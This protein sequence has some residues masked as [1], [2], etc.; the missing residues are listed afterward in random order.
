MRRLADD[1]S[2]YGASANNQSNCPAL[3]TAALNFSTSHNSI[4][5]QREA[6]HGILGDQVIS[7][8]LFAYVEVLIEKSCVLH[9]H[10]HTS[11]SLYYIYMNVS[12]FLVF[13]Y[14]RVRSIIIVSWFNIWESVL[15]LC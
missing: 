14:S 8:L 5:E 10:V 7:S 4:E 1:C 3:A 2:K 13:I 11:N 15:I 9:Y 6:L 12:V